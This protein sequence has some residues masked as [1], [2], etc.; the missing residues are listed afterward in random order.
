MESLIQLL[1]DKI[2]IKF[3]GK[4]NRMKDNRVI[5]FLKII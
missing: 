2:K 3:A 1:G 4:L 5:G